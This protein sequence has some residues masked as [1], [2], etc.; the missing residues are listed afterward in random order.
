MA[1][2]KSLLQN[3]INNYVSAD[4]IFTANPKNISTFVGSIFLY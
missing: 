4:L 1:V 2:S 3:L